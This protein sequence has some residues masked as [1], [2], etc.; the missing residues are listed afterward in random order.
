MS[1]AYG[2][3]ERSMPVRLLGKSLIFFTIARLC[4]AAYSWHK[5]HTFPREANGRLEKM[6]VHQ[7]KVLSFSNQPCETAQSGSEKG[8]KLSSRELLG[9]FPGRVRGLQVRIEKGG[10][11]LLFSC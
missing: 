1:V 2:A 10:A 8:K 3:V 7:S 11:I 5:S 4:D 9:A 6:F